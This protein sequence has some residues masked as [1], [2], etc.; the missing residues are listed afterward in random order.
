MSDRARGGR[1]YGRPAADPALDELAAE[2]GELAKRWAI[3]LIE[4]ADPERIAAPD[5]ALIAGEGPALIDALLSGLPASAQLPGASQRE[6]PPGDAGAA[7][8]VP[9]GVAALA[10]ARDAGELAR[11]VESLRSVLWEAAVEASPRA[12]SEPRAARRLAELGDA[13]A[14]ACSELLAGELDRFGARAGAEVAEAPAPVAAAAVPSAGG[15]SVVIVDER[16]ILAPGADAA[17]PGYEGGLAGGEREIPGG[18]PGDERGRLEHHLRGREQPVARAAELHRDA[19]AAHDARPR[20][21]PAAWIGSIGAQLEAYEHDRRPFAVL[22]IELLEPAVPPGG[23]RR[24]EE[25]GPGLELVLEERLREGSALSL[26]RERPG[27]Y[28]V[29]APATDRAG[30]ETLRE[31][32]EAALGVSRRPAAVA[33]GAAVCPEDATDAPGLAAQADLDLYASRPR[34]RAAPGRGGAGG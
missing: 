24:A 25:G 13:L 8:S 27:R 30:A 31:R 6:E 18:G 29:V 16:G 1:G 9:G 11:A 21:G 2:A 10:G 19:I 14:G 3:A 12:R 33:I 26:T 5:L 4:R 32:L 15:T 34:A 22:L 20:Q 23:H 7:G 28:W 17:G